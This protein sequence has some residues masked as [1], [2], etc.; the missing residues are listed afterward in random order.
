MS[1]S[2]AKRDLYTAEQFM[3]EKPKRR[4]KVN[5]AAKIPDLPA[6]VVQE[7]IGPFQDQ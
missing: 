2:R 4:A 5:Q 3:K 7:A 6:G 1:K